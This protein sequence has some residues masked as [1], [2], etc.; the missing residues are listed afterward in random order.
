[1]L[2]ALALV[3]LVSTAIAVTPVKSATLMAYD[4]DE[5]CGICPLRL[6]YMDPNLGGDPLVDCGHFFGLACFQLD[7]G[8]SNEIM[9]GSTGI[10]AL[11]QISDVDL[12]A[13]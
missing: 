4:E 1:M 8:N 2:K 7:K 13:T 3:A 10:A 5:N 6:S 11:G 12:E 9:E